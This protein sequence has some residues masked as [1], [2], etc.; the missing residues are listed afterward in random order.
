MDR[1][2][3]E[4]KESP[5]AHGQ[6]RIYVA[7]EKSYARMEKYRREGVP[8]GVKVVEDLKKISNDLGVPW[9]A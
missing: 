8:L 1:L 9:P 5:K 7:G 3:R 4:L 6:P 2:A